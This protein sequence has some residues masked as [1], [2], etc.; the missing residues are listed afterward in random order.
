MADDLTTAVGSPNTPRRGHGFAGRFAILIAICFIYV[1]FVGSVFLGFSGYILRLNLER[2][3]SSQGGIDKL[4]FSI[5]EVATLGRE[6]QTA[7]DD[8][9]AK[10]LEIANKNGDIAKFK[11]EF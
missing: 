7:S 8:V 9:A 5:T 6:L 2:D 1:G 4:L 11:G 10:Q 3:L